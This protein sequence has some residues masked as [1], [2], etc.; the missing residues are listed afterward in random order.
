[1][2]LAELS[3]AESKHRGIFC[4]G[5]LTVNAYQALAYDYFFSAFSVIL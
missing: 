2:Y 3:G 5:N 4:Q 1:M